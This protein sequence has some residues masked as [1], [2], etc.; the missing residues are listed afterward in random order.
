MIRRMTHLDKNLREQIE[1][2]V[3]WR[4]HM[5]ELNK[6]PDQPP[7]Y[8]TTEAMRSFLRTL[9]LMWMDGELDDGTFKAQ[10]R[11]M[12]MNEMPKEKPA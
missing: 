4:R 9:L 5:I 6:D 11:A 1:F 7:I 12:L 3:I 8:F 10:L 2:D